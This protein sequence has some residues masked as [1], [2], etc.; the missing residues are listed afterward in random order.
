MYGC[1]LVEQLEC[2]FLML[3]LLESFPAMGLPAIVTAKFAYLAL[4]LD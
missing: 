4:G 3:E 2:S 1:L